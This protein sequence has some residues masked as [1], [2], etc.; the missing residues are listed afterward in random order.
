MKVQNRLAKVAEVGKGWRRKW[1]S[2][3]LGNY[4]AKVASRWHGECQTG[5]EAGC[6]YVLMYTGRYTYLCTY[7]CALVRLDDAALSMLAVCIMH[8]FRLRVVMCA[9]HGA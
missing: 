1:W 7:V 6:T 9:A 5:A 4:W 2:F 8:V 3:L